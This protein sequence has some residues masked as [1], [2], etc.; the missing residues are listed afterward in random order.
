MGAGSVGALALGA[1]AE[2]KG[3]DTAAY[4]PKPPVYPDYDVFK[5]VYAEH[6]GHGHLRV[7]EASSL[8]IV[9][10]DR[11]GVRVQDS[12]TGKWYWDCHRVG[13]LYNL[14]HRHPR[15]VAALREAFE[16]LE[17]GNAHMLTQYKAWAAEKL[18]AS[19]GG[20]LPGVIYTSSGT[21][22]VE[23]SIKTARGVT[24]RRRIVALENSYHGHSIMTIAAAGNDA[25]RKRYLADYPDEFVRVPWNDFKAMEKAV[26]DHTAGVLLEPMPA[27]MGFPPPKPGYLERVQ[28][29]CRDRGALLIMDE[30]ITGVGGTGTFWL[31]QQEGIVPDVLATAKGI[32]GGLQANAAALLKPEH[33]RW[34]GDDYLGHYTTFGGNELGCVATAVTCDVI[35]EPGF[36]EHVRAVAKRFADGFADAPFELSQRGLCM[37]LMLPEPRNSEVVRRLY[38]SG[39]IVAGGLPDVVQLRVPLVVSF[40]EADEIIGIVNRVAKEV[41]G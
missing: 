17:I 1:T 7:R 37:G 22:A 11:E 13:S 3:A 28:K 30:V 16:L 2:G 27:R 38:E 19:T 9:I 14:G 24:R 26:D 5:E 31:Y 25:H 41:F 15:V 40:D 23:V 32:G 8:T 6:V 29:L 33:Y 10:G 36:L 21:E 34:L 35:M 20:Q 39:V 18:A 4:T 12:Y